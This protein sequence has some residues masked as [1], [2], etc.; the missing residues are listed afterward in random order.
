MTMSIPEKIKKIEEAVEII[1]QYQ[2][3]LHKAL[4]DEQPFDLSC[5]SPHLR[6]MN[7]LAPELPTM[8]PVLRVQVQEAV[9]A[10]RKSL[11]SLLD[12]ANQYKEEVV[13]ESNKARGHTKSA[14][15]Y[16]KAGNG[17]DH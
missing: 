14:A 3:N 16:A 7:S 15:A 5:L 12:T 2:E 4:E 11:D 13:D 9:A 10:F 8:D 17:A 1:N 6:A